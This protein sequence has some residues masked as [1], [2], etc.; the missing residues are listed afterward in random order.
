MRVPIADQKSLLR[1]TR[2]D[3]LPDVGVVLE[4]DGGEAVDEV[5]AG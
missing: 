3:D 1:K 2:P 5:G 4:V